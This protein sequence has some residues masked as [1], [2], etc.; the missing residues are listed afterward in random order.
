MSSVAER[1]DDGAKSEVLEIGVQGDMGVG[2]GAVCSS[3]SSLFE[4]AG[5]CVFPVPGSRNEKKL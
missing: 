3:T 1:F 4:A 5:M 2:V